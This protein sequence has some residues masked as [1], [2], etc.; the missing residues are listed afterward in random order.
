MHRV[1]FSNPIQLFLK[2]HPRREK[3]FTL[4]WTVTWKQGRF[5]LHR[6]EMLLLAPRHT[7]AAI[8]HIPQD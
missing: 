8:D 7:E 5:F 6:A 3:G 1:S 2:G 4:S